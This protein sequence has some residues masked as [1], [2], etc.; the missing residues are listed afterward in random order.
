MLGYTDTGIYAAQSLQAIGPESLPALIQGMDSSNRN[1]RIF[2]LKTIAL[3]GPVAEASVPRTAALMHDPDRFVAGTAMMTLGEMGAA[4]QPYLPELEHNL[5]DTNYCEFAGFALARLNQLEPLL[6]ALTNEQPQVRLTAAASLNPSLRLV[7][8][9]RMHP[10][11]FLLVEPIGS[12]PWVTRELSNPRGAYAGRRFIQILLANFEQ[13]EPGVRALVAERLGDYGVKAW[14]AIPALTE[15]LNDDN[16]EHVHQSAAAALKKI[17]VQLSEG[18]VIR[19]PRNEK[20]IALEFTGH[21]F[22]EGGETILDELAKHHALASFFV[23]GDFLENTNFQPLVERIVN[24]GHYLG[25]HG[26]KHLLYCPWAG[27]K[28]TLVTHQDFID[29]LTGNLNLLTRPADGRGYPLV[30]RLR[31][32]YWLPAYEWYNEQ[33]VEWSREL[34]VAL[35]SYT[36]GT[37]S[38]ADYTEEAAAN[39]VSSQAIYDSIIKKDQTAPNG[40]NGCLLLLHLG[41]GSGRADKFADHHFGELLDYLTARGYQFVRIDDLLDPRQ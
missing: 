36:P 2:C 18:G 38:N 40:L 15:T 34:R 26:G 16:D 10:D 1:T 12:V 11:L 7:A 41:A 21:T 25:A 39:F 33:I 27:P 30:P 4:A 17:D 32:R 19:G 28:D 31:P 35:V 5:A 13:P 22:A 3:F 24:E 14:P 9:T 6:L 8:G 20:K 23:T 37:R 29:D